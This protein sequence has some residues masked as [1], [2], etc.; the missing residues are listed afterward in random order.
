M[1]TEITFVVLT[2]PN[3]H[4]VIDAL[5]SIR[6]LGHILLIDG[7]LRRDKKNYNVDIILD[8]QEVAK[9]FDATY[10][11]QNFEYAAKQYNLGISMA[12]TKWIF[13]LDSDEIIGQELYD[14]LGQ[15]IQEN[16]LLTHFS[17]RRENYFLNKRMKHGHFRPD[18]NIRFFRNGYGIYED[19]QVHAR[20]IV[21]GKSGKTTASLLHY[22]VNDLDQFFERMIQYTKRDLNARNSIN[23]SNESKAKIRRIVQKFPFQP[24]IRFFYSYF[25]KLGFLDGRVGFLLA[26]SSSFYE[27]MIK[28]RKEFEIESN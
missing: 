2:T 26:K 18:Y 14:W 22:T 11:F 5:K 20:L 7:G 19:R 6:N 10:V 27:T 4:E 12:K 1:M 21:S 23:N 17:I 8:I 9:K 24:T 16:T 25:I 13:I 28:L 15:I 3:D